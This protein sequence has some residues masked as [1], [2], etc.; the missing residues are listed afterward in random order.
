[1]YSQSAPWIS[2]WRNGV[3]SGN[4]LCGN[5]A[6]ICRALLPT[7]A[8]YLDTIGVEPVCKQLIIHFTPNIINAS[9]TTNIHQVETLNFLQNK[10][11][12]F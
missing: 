6:N 7:K 8:L 1:M 3:F 4:Y 2:T 5:I 12:K 10:H 11:L 9:G